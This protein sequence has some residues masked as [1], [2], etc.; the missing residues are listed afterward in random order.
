[1]SDERISTNFSLHEFERSAYAES[2]GIGN[3]IPR[4]S[5]IEAAVRELV[6][7]VL[8]PLRTAYGMPL[9]VNSGYRCPALNSAV[10]GVRNSQHMKG[11]AA[12]IRSA[13]S[14]ESYNLASIAKSLKLPYDQIGLSD[15]FVH[16]SHRLNGRQRGMIF[17]YGDYSG[18][19][20][21]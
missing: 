2:H 9:T 4:G 18:S 10:G 7:T 20:L 6:L 14:A 5:D 16:I 3:A 8:Q 21:Y 17:Y 12:D 1:M 19:K 13:S 15:R 11:E